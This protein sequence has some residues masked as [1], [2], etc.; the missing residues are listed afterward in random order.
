MT[1]Q[2]DRDI[3][4]QR[5]SP[6]KLGMPR[7]AENGERDSAS[8]EFGRG[9]GR[10]QARLRALERREKSVSLVCVRATEFVGMIAGSDRAS[11]PRDIARY[12]ISSEFNT[13]R[14]NSDYTIESKDYLK[15]SRRASLARVRIQHENDYCRFV[16]RREY[17]DTGTRKVSTKKQRTTKVNSPTNNPR[18][19]R[20]HD[21][22][23]C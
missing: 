9:A 12:G 3:F 15:S 10:I 18:A 21:A 20:R 6:D 4:F 2:L 11:S 1:Q 23:R 17:I 8:T 19:D 7:I 22:D 14:P 13:L 16:T 5:G